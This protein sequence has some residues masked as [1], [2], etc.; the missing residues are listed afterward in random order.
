MVRIVINFGQ[1]Q[2]CEA[3]NASL[4]GHMDHSCHR[5]AR[6]DRIYGL[7]IDRY[8]PNSCGSNIAGLAIM[9]WTLL[10]VKIKD[11]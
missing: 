11:Y 2:G 1:L 5:L 9:N 7:N 10:G 3:G 8:V 4:I 6:A